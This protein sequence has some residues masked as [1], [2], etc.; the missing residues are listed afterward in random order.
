MHFS[1]NRVNFT[2]SSVAQ[3]N[4]V[5]FL[6]KFRSTKQGIQ[7]IVTILG[8]HTDDVFSSGTKKTPKALW[9]RSFYKCIKK[10][11]SLVPYTR[12]KKLKFQ[13]GRTSQWLSVAVL[14][15]NKSNS[16]MYINCDLKVGLI[17]IRFYVCKNG[18]TL[19]DIKV[20]KTIYCGC[21]ND[22]KENAA[23]RQM[24][25]NWFISSVTENNHLKSLLSLQDLKNLGIQYCTHLL[26]AGVLR[27]I[28]DKDAPTEYIFKPNLMYYWAHMEVPASQPVTPG[29]LHMSA[30]LPDKDINRL[31]QDNL[32]DKNNFKNQNN[33]EEISDISEA[34]ILISQ[35]KRKL[36]DLEYQLE[37]YKINTQIDI[38]N[39][40][41]EKGF[42]SITEYNLLKNKTDLISKEVQT[43]NTA[44]ELNN[45]SNKTVIS[46]PECDPV[47]TNVH[48]DNI[49]VLSSQGGINDKAIQDDT[50]KPEIRSEK[51]ENYC[52]L[53][54]S[55][56]CN[57]V[58]RKESLLEYESVE[59]EKLPVNTKITKETLSS[60][61][62]VNNSEQSTFDTICESSSEASFLSSYASADLI[63]TK[64]Q[65]PLDL[66]KTKNVALKNVSSSTNIPS[67]QV[68]YT[69]DKKQ[70]ELVEP[71][72]P[73]HK[74]TNNQD[75]IN[76]PSL[77][78][79]HNILKKNKV[80]VSISQRR[81]S[82]D[83]VFLRS[84][85]E[86]KE[87]EQGSPLPPPLPGMPPHP[88]PT[89]GTDGTR[90]S[91]TYQ[92]TSLP[93]PVLESSTS[94]YKTGPSPPP[95]PEMGLSPSPPPP[96]PMPAMDPQPPLMSDMGSPPSPMSKMVPPPP[97][98]SGMG[99]PPP[100]MP[101]MGPPPP[102]MPGMGPPPPPMP[103]M[104]PP[105]PP[106]PGM[107][108][109]PP[110]MPGLGPPPPP[111]P[112]MGPPPPPMPGM[113][114]PP[115]PMPG[116]GPPPPPMPG[117]G[118]PPP[119]MPGMGPPPPPM[120]GMGPPPPPMP[121]FAVSPPSGIHPPPPPMPGAGPP[122]IPGLGPGP[123]PPPSSSLGPVPFP[124][125]PV[126][127]WNMQR[128]TLRKTPVKPAAPM[129][130]LYWTRILAAPPVSSCQGESEPS[131]KPLWLEIDETPLDNIDEFTD[132]FSRQ[133]VK[134][135]AKKKV[136]VKTK[137][138][139]VK[140]L[141]SKRSQNVGILAQ[142]LHVE[143]SEIENAIYNFDTSV[144][145]L[146]ALQQ[147][148]ELRANEEELSMIKEH[149]KS[150]PDIPLDRP[151]AFLHDLSGIPNF[152]E[153]IS[154]FMF[155]ADF[156]DSISTTMHKLDN[157]KHTCEFLT[158]SESLKKLFAII[159]T[160]GNYMNGGNGQ[161]GQADGFGLEILAKLKDVKSKQSNVTLLH[162]IVRTYMR[163]CGGALSGACAL[164]VPEP[165]DVARAAAL[166]FNDVAAHLNDLDKQLKAC[167]GKTKKVI[168]SDTQSR[169]VAEEH[170]GSET[171]KD[172]TDV[173]KEKMTTFIYA[174][175][176]KLKTENENLDECRNKFIATVKFYQYTP[177]CGKVE[178]CEPKEFFSL[179]TSFCSDFKDIYKKE[180]QIA[181]KEKLKEAKKLQ[182]ERKSLTQP[183][184]EG[185]LKARLQKLSS[186]R[187]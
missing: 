29:R 127:G 13:F 41:L 37:K 174:A 75:V 129:K 76:G 140:I 55:R 151:E 92:K 40:N 101:G 130:P 20:T 57:N 111:M 132:L 118:P 91:T 44:S 35:L 83:D 54:K 181:I 167:K 82:T 138:Q 122:G 106:M 146:E 24:L 168:E 133:V 68:L 16:K 89:P 36:K 112:G 12:V 71:I 114:P 102:P 154:C 65:S 123:P 11:D 108:P 85:E 173:F 107:G 96:M 69:M 34:K 145:S 94:F 17:E 136:E 18:H 1:A 6:N 74:Q 121:G 95:M 182:D 63:V 186:S 33:N 60:L 48:I 3:I 98:M 64:E 62:P 21:W 52:K 104:G 4:Y 120:P 73:L 2:S 143:F 166:D 46:K 164:P 9:R 124:A 125:P 27:Q 142:S 105:P 162:F 45:L 49:L 28:P 19:Y 149:L 87:L 10:K 177:K 72:Q 160:L 100:P 119:P 66:N 31:S 43:F 30:W 47:R 115:P 80:D 42:E 78:N 99:P 185:G 155:Q 26:A 187:K 135:P 184:K 171:K 38:L 110:P 5:E 183:I 93:S 148:Y 163:R 137:I 84:D 139:P 53:N 103:G 170:Q 156:E 159:L 22:R 150:K 158:T 179:W 141:D 86:P 97:P 157:L 152:A 51:I 128:S 23:N 169:N 176:E 15:I 67:M 134:A 81:E 153:R 90:V 161:R 50:S 39:K 25:L 88:P 165:G 32:I 144:V 7:D 59:S 175:E 117:M 180:E 58:F 131:S 116:L 70:N 178:E 56:D 14:V 147:I 8:V 113:G 109:P 126:G 61:E 79:Q 172:N 77:N